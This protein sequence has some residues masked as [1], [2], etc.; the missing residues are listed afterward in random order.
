MVKKFKRKRNR[1]KGKIVKQKDLEILR[2][3]KNLPVKRSSI[4]TMKHPRKRIHFPLTD[5]DAITQ[6]WEVDSDD[7]CVKVVT[8]TYHLEHKGNWHDVIRFDSEHGYLDCHHRLSVQDKT[9]I[10]APQD[11]II[12]KG[13]PQ[14]WM[15]WARNTVQKSFMNY[16]KGFLKRSGIKGYY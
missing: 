11:W 8:V 6:V 2:L 4:V 7:I 15:E 3:V 14:A 13:E 1:L 16:R 9:E 5:F 10:R 12:E